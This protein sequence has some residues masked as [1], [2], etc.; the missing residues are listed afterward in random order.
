MATD[1]SAK[2]ALMV[3]R[4]TSSCAT[5]THQTAAQNRPSHSTRRATTEK[6]LIAQHAPRQ[7]AAYTCVGSTSTMCTWK[8]Q[9]PCQHPWLPENGARIR[10]TLPCPVPKEGQRQGWGGPTSC[11]I[12]VLK[13]AGPPEARPGGKCT[14]TLCQHRAAHAKHGH[15][16]CSDQC[17]AYTRGLQVDRRSGRSAGNQVQTH[18]SAPQFRRGGTSPSTRAYRPRA[19][20][21]CWSGT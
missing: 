8:Q 11:F 2:T 15:Q 17:L 5:D 12:E 13:L 18:P 10:C 1:W 3:I 20:A 14:H 16:E 4:P 7:R 19:S 6:T 21:L 9:Q